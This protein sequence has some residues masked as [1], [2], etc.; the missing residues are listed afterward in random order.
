MIFNSTSASGASNNLAIWL[1]EDTTLSHYA[2]IHSK[3]DSDY[4]TLMVCGFTAGY[5]YGPGYSFGS[6][7]IFGGTAV[8]EGRNRRAATTQQ[9][10]IFMH[11]LA[12]TTTL[13]KIWVRATATI[14]T[15]ARMK[16]WRLS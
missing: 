8:I 14:A 12:S 16:I 3:S 4:N 13:T 10:G 2:V 9:M 1:N 15:G 5:N 6:I 7:R 11:T